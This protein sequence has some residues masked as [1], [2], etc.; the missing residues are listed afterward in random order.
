MRR[1]SNRKKKERN[2][3]RKNRVRKSIKKRKK[4]LRKRS[5][6][7][8]KDRKRQRKHVKFARGTKKPNW[9]HEEPRLM[10]QKQIKYYLS[11]CV[12]GFTG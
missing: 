3:H 8:S 11:L 7:T 6:K 9:K 10:T 2:K 4:I 12:D 5:R 1:F